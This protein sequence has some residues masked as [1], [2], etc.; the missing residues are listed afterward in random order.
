MTD[1]ESITAEKNI[2]KRENINKKTMIRLNILDSKIEKKNIAL[3]LKR[4]NL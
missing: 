3:F 4:L 1:N 2:I